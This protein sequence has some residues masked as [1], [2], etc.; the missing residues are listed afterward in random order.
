MLKTNAMVP[1]SKPGDLTQMTL[2][3]HFIGDSIHTI[4]IKKTEKQ[5]LNEKYADS[6]RRIFSEEGY[7]DSLL[8]PKRR[9]ANG[10]EMH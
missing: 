10:I 1:T 2:S 5:E 3:I 4:F 7:L 6:L 9:I 8:M